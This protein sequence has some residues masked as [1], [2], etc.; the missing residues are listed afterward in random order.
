[1]SSAPPVR[2]NRKS[3]EPAKACAQ[4]QLIQ[5]GGGWQRQQA[6]KQTQQAR[7]AKSAGDNAK[8]GESKTKTHILRQRVLDGERARRGGAGRGLGQRG[9]ARGAVWGQKRTGRR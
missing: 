1:M 5:R 6:V 9:G 7:K 4:T 3:S 8:H 2:V